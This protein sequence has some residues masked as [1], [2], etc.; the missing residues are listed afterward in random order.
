ML[1]TALAVAQTNSFEVRSVALPLVSVGRDTGWGFDDDYQ[2]RVTGNGSKP[3]VLEVYSPEVNRNDYG[4]NRKVDTYFGDELFKDGDFS[5]SFILGDP[6][7]PVAKKDFGLSDTHNLKRIF[8][9][10]LRPGSYPF[11]VVSNGPGKNSFSVRASGSVQFEASQFSVNLRG[12]PNEDQL[13][14][15]V[16]MGKNAVGQVARLSNYDADGETEMQMSLILPDGTVKPLKIS[17]DHALATTDIS[18][19]NENIGRWQIVARVLATSKQFSNSFGVKLQLEDQKLFAS[20][21]AFEAPEV[22]SYTV[23]FVDLKG[24]PIENATYSVEGENTRVIQPFLPACYQL[25]KASVLDGTGTVNGNQVSMTTA[26][27]TIRFVAACTSIKV[28]VV[29]LLCNQ[30]IPLG[31]VPINVNDVLSSS[32]QQIALAPGL[33]TIT[34]KTVADATTQSRQ[35]KLRLGYQED[36]TVTYHVTPKISISPAST[37][38]ALN[39]PQE[40]VATA[41]TAFPYP[42]STTLEML[43]PSVIMAKGETTVTGA[44]SDQHPLELR[45]ALS[46][47]EDFRIRSVRATL[48]GACST[49]STVTTR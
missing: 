16:N 25:V 44:L 41:S 26:A 29:A 38:L 12:K 49:H 30:Q 2:L 7:N 43:V 18:V 21:P 4:V 48:N 27:G 8:E 46:R 36:V 11:S 47:Q 15:F 40:F 14:A 10:S 42:L 32:E 5:S 6:R 1:L 3:T 22:K 24:E 31:E 19:T 13:V 33:I 9:G 28:H 17:G 34:P 20:V 23:E 39:E 45:V 35:I 37:Q